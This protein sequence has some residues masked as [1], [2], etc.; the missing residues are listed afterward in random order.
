MLSEEFGTRFTK[1]SEAQKQTRT[2]EFVNGVKMES[3]TVRSLAS[4]K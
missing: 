1:A 2:Q 4:Y 3:V